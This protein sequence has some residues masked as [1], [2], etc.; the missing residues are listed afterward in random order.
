MSTMPVTFAEGNDNASYASTDGSINSSVVA[1]LGAPRLSRF[2][3]EYLGALDAGELYPAGPS[4]YDRALFKEQAALTLEAS[5]WPEQEVKRHAHRYLSSFE[6]PVSPPLLK[7][8]AHGLSTHHKQGPNT[9]VL[10]LPQPWPRPPSPGYVA[11]ATQVNLRL[12]RA[13][14]GLPPLGFGTGI[15][16]DA[17]AP[18]MN[19]SVKYGENVRGYAT[20]PTLAAAAPDLSDVNWRQALD[21]PANLRPL[22]GSVD[23]PQDLR[24]PPRLRLGP[25]V[26]KAPFGPGGRRERDNI[27]RVNPPGS[28][29]GYG[30]ASMTKTGAATSAT[31]TTT[32]DAHPGSPRRSQQQHRQQRRRRR[33]HRRGESSAFR[34]EVERLHGEHHTNSSGAEVALERP[35]WLVDPQRPSAVFASSSGRVATFGD[36]GGRRCASLHDRITLF[37]TLFTLQPHYNLILPVLSCACSACVGGVRKTVKCNLYA[38]TKCQNCSWWLSPGILR[39]RWNLLA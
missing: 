23:H 33:R 28:G 31:A 20:Q 36:Q 29:G 22:P 11:D 39:G 17:P 4:A 5:K 35:S 32:T 3:R 26:A 34:S 6:K 10:P 27:E 9:A 18:G 8:R 1:V 21:M 38:G 19:A 30:G 25:Q 7:A 2:Q 15:S 14:A 16:T 24:Q 12:A 37:W 13:L